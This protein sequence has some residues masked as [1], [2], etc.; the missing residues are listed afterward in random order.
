M[1]KVLFMRTGGIKKE[2]STQMLRFMFAKFILLAAFLDFALLSEVSRAQQLMSSSAPETSDNYFDMS[3]EE[4]MKVDIR[5]GKPGWFG[6]QLEQLN[7]DPYVH[8]YA[9]A[10]YRDFDFNRGR[11]VGTFDMHY[12]NVIVG[13][14]IGE[15]SGR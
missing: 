2:G 4:L 13:A 7:V 10:I 3:L 14:N 11:E 15:K 5:T 1:S 9:A 6:T 12:F 8:G